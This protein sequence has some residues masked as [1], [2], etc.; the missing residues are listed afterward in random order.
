MRL[1]PGLSTLIYAKFNTYLSN[2]RKSVPCEGV[3]WKAIAV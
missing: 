3:R 1:G 2:Q